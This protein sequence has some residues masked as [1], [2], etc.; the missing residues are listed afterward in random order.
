MLGRRLDG[1]FVDLLIVESGAKSKTIQKYLGK[2][3]IVA[4]CNGHVRDLPTSRQTKDGKKAMW[5]SSVEKLPNPPWEWTENSERTIG[6]L[7]SKAQEKQVENVYIATDPDR[8]GEFIA[9]QLKLIFIEAGFDN[10]WRVTFNEITK[11]AVQIA[12]DGKGDVNHNLVSAAKVRRFMD[13]LVGVRASKFSRSWSLP[14][15]GRVQTPTLGF[16]VDKEIEREQFVPQPYFSV[17]ADAGG[18]RWN[19]RFHEKSDA[20][21]WVDDKGKFHATRTNDAKLAESALEA[22]T[23][24][25]TL[26]RVEPGQYKS[27]PD[28]PFTTDTLLMKAGSEMNW[29]PGRTMKVA[30]E[31]YNAG[32]ITYIRTD[33]SRTSAGARD[34]VKEFIKETWGQDHLGK[35]VV[36]PDVKG[37]KANVQD[38]HEAIRPTRPAVQNIEGVST[39]Q[40]RL[41]RLIWSRFAASQMSPSQY[42]RLSMSASASGFEKSFTST[43]SWRVH[44]G[45]EA[46]FEGIR[47]EPAIS[48]PSFNAS[49][50][51]SLE[52]DSEDVESSNPQL[53][54]DE[55]KPPARYKQHSIV[56]KMKSEGIG[57]PSTYA[58]TI[59]KLL[60]RKYVLEENGSLIP[61]ESG[62]TL[63]LEV[64]PFYDRSSHGIEGH[65]FGTEFTSEMESNL[66]EIEIGNTAA[67]QVWHTFSEHFQG[68]HLSALELKKQKPTPKQLDYF[69]RLTSNL[70]EEETAR[71]TG[72]KSPEDITGTEMR[73]AIE[74]INKVHPAESQPASEK[75]LNWISSL[76]E[77][78]NLSETEACAMVEVGSFSDLTG[79]RKGTASK[80]IE[81]L[82]PLAN[83]APR[84]ASEKQIKYIKS[85][86]EKAGMS[87]SEA[88]KLVEAEEYTQ[89]QGG[90]G[91]TAS[92]LITQLRKLTG[93]KKKKKGKSGKS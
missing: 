76:A 60:S 51:E 7:I 25:L 67:P 85:M 49:V 92:N 26:S 84:E 90:A 37:D 19:A 18:L 42:E 81:T 79:G 77:G 43:A 20:E 13:R 27:N 88:C 93:G 10:V 34:E 89:L 41:Y 64:A 48:P 28:P 17:Y 61:A 44:R 32:H 29:K 16:I 73:E 38:A 8:E 35:G 80:L 24:G 30:G 58:A 6:N 52:L 9:W 70:S 5:A 56:Q 65:L 74:E 4:A 12:I 69:A 33:S 55:T 75:Q 1:K 40:S 83:L 46:A 78:A 15:M 71:F 68:L 66:D 14:A 54:E 2:G 3:W 39:E 47:K 11:A 45:W 23:G 53:I 50:G 22:A 82:R 62:R 86:V 87:E 21:A 63:W 59:T 31:L 91:G 72:G 57:R 36:G